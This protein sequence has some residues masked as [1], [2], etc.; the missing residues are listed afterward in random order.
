MSSRGRLRSGPESQATEFRY[1]RGRQPLHVRFAH[2]SLLEGTGFEASVPQSEGGPASSWCQFSFAGSWSPS[3]YGRAGD[4]EYQTSILRL[5][6]ERGMVRRERLFLT[7]DT[8]PI[9]DQLLDILDDIPGDVRSRVASPFFYAGLA[10]RY[11]SERLTE[12][13]RDNL[14]ERINRLRPASFDN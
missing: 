1:E 6:G 9:F 3:L 8:L 11:E 12:D 4:F 10:I 13:D 5:A 2:D 7:Q 14:P